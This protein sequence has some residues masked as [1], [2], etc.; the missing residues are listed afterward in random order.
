M[1]YTIQNYNKQTIL[2]LLD[3]L[4][5]TTATSI[6]LIGKNVENFGL[7][8]NENYVWLLE[9]FSSAS[10]PSNPIPGQLWYNSNEKQ[11]N[12][13]DGNQ[14]ILVGPQ[15]A[16]NFAF[17]GVRPSVVNDQDLQ[18]KPIVEV[19]VNDEILAILSREQFVLSTT[20][21]IPGFS[22]LYRGINFKNY[23]QNN[24]DVML[25][26]NSVSATTATN[27]INSTTQPLDNVSTAIA[28]TQF[29]HNILPRGVILLWA[30]NAGNIPSGWALCD[31]TNGTP[32]LSSRF[33]LGASLTLNA[34]T[35]G[36]Q[37]TISPITNT[38]GVHS[39]TSKTGNT[40]LTIDQIPPHTHTLPA[41]SQPTGAYTQ[42]L[43]STPND[44]EDLSPNFLT[45]ATGGGQPHDHDIQADG[46]HF[47][48]INPVSIMPPWYA[49]CYIMKVTG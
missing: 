40:T 8:Q 24:N 2:T 6:N 25:Y 30:G 43:T 19:V 44:D 17:T 7:L 46:I 21:E 34:N 12:L 41:D 14:F 37:S 35:T 47:H 38:S 39:H 33:I 16:G 29:V 22:I 1:P 36:G 32:N 26:G 5:N 11:L 42:S 49:L 9:N 48:S 23:G 27:A 4:V 45:G 15:R 3:G 31:G 18:Q 13:Y 20:N 28:N 10:P